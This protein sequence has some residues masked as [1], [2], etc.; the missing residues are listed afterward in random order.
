MSSNGGKS[1]DHLIDRL[2]YFEQALPRVVGKFMGEV[3][4]VALTEVV[5]G[6]PVDTGAARSN[7][8]VSRGVE[9]DRI[10]P[11]H[12]PYPKFTDPEKFFEVV[13]TE[14]AVDD[15]A[16]VLAETGEPEG[17]GAPVFIQNSVDYIGALN[18]EGHSDQNTAFV[19][20]AVL[21][22]RRAIADGELGLVNKDHGNV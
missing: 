13:N 3:A 16:R 15:G 17:L 21:L 8:I 19:E 2:E 4:K 22:A 10:I 18:Y 5:S 20:S 11:P 12:F 14:A 7:W 6:T 9:V 1:L